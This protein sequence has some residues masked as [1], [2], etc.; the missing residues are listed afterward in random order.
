MVI[1]MSAVPEGQREE[2]VRQLREIFEALERA[3]RAGRPIG[4]KVEPVMK[5]TTVPGDHFESFA[6]TG[7]CTVTIRA[8]VKDL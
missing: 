1:S 4:V 8:V 6:P 3:V 7:E 2:T 5:E